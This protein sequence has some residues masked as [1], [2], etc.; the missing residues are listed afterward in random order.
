MN[1][2][3][4][5]DD[6][7]DAEAM[8][9]IAKLLFAERDYRGTEELL[10]RAV[11]LRPASPD[12]HYSLGNALMSLERILEAEQAYLQAARLDPEHFKARNNA[13]LCALRQG[14]LGEA[15]AHFQ[16]VLRLHPGDAIAQANLD[17]VAQAM[18][19]QPPAK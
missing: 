11:A 7:T 6:P 1:R 10:R 5:R 15:A 17:L 18:R 9:E 2:Q 3:L 13:G 12:V 4:L 14:K 16:A 8:V 19:G